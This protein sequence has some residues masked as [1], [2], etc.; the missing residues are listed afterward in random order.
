MKTEPLKKIMFEMMSVDLKDPPVVFDL[1][2]LFTYAS[3]TLMSQ[4]PT[5]QHAYL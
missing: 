2:W 5:D 4:Q 3:L 1:W